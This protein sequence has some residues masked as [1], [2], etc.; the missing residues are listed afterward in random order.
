VMGAF[1]ISKSATE[2]HFS[3]CVAKVLC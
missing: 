2:L 1:A 3:L